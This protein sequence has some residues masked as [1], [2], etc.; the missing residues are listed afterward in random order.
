MREVDR[1]PELLDPVTADPVTADPV[2][3]YDRLAPFYREISQP[4]QRYLNRIERLVIARVPAGSRSLLDVGAGDGVRTSIIA[5]GAGLHDAV[6]L[7]PSVEMA[8]NCRSPAEFWAIRAEELGSPGH[9]G[10]RP[11]PLH[12]PEGRRFDVITCLWN[13]LGHIRPA[14]NRA[15]VLCELE[16][17]LSARGVMFLDVNHRYNVGSYGLFR[18]VGR[19]VFDRLSPGEVNGDVTATWKLGAAQCSAYG[20]VF[21]D[22]EVRGLAASAGLTIRERVVVDYERGAVRRFGF[23]GNLLYVFHRNQPEKRP[24]R[25]NKEGSQATPRF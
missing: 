18:T 22:R 24:R 10:N 25:A 5:Q 12:S 7:E 23:E 17:L 16:G 9:D 3:A 15:H 1:N 20:H 14:E 6:L 2:T 11:R 19:Y 21:T 4:R 8:R 13:V